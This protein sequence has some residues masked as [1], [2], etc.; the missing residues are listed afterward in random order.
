[1]LY[2]RNAIRILNTGH[3]GINMKIHK[4]NLTHFLAFCIFSTMCASQVSPPRAISESRY[5]KAHS[6][7]ENYVFDP[8]DG[9]QTVNVT[10]LQY[11]YQRRSEIEANDGTSITRRAK[12]KGISGAIA[13]V[14]KGVFKGLKGLGKQ[15]DATVT[16]CASKVDASYQPN[17]IYR[18]TGHDLLN[19]SCWSN[20]KW[21]PSV[22]K[23][24]PRIT[25]LVK[26]SIG[27][28]VCLCTHHG[29]MEESSKVLQILGR[30]ASRPLKR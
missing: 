12:A 25:A 2:C 1:M 24:D 21:S 17:H 6:L 18:Y 30:S 27:Q 9:W 15:E 28:V 14:L 8:R 16:W 3:W 23:D 11:K 4:L 10:N 20:G 19:P 26:K 29:R 7:G 13:S 22:R 5:D